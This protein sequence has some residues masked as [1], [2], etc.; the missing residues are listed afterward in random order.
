MIP[1]RALY[2]NLRLDTIIAMRAITG[3]SYCELKACY[4]D[5][6]CRH[7]A[8]SIGQHAI[9]HYAVSFTASIAEP[10]TRGDAAASCQQRRVA[11]TLACRQRECH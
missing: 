1:P 6:S 2:L 8:A 4:E 7:Y 5:D 11:T 3:E 10:H 9:R